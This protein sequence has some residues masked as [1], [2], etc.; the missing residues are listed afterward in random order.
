MTVGH[1]TGTDF[2]GLAVGKDLRRDGTIKRS[3]ADSLATQPFGAVKTKVALELRQ[4]KFRLADFQT[5]L[6]G[7]EVDSD[8]RLCAFAKRDIQ[9]DPPLE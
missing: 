3:G 9:V 1:H 6:V 5:R 7:A 8:L 2:S 4:F